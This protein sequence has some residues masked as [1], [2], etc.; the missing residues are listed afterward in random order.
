MESRKQATVKYIETIQPDKISKAFYLDSNVPMVRELPYYQYS[1]PKLLP[2]AENYV[3]KVF[4][5]KII[6]SFEDLA[7]EMGVTKYMP[8]AY[9]D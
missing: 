9:S 7:I 8:E 5:G 2:K 3:T 4:R 1:V 6:S